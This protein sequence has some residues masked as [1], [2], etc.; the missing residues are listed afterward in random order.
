MIKKSKFTLPAAVIT[1]SVIYLFICH[2]IFLSLLLLF[3]DVG[4]TL[5]YC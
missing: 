5:Y 3:F 2:L 1:S 4:F